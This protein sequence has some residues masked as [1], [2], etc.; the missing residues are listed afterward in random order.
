M[1][2]VQGPRSHADDRHPRA[3]TLREGCWTFPEVVSDLTWACGA[4]FFFWQKTEVTPPRNFEAFGNLL[5]APE[6]REKC[7]TVN[8]T[9]RCISH[10]LFGVFQTQIEIS[11][12]EIAVFKPSEALERCELLVARCARRKR[13]ARKK[14]VRCGGKGFG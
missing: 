5:C 7:T 4:L 13:S 1:G 2:L 14:S 11:K 9:Q 10:Q 3:E 6:A 12:R 8:F